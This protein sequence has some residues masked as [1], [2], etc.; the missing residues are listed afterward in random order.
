MDDAALR[1]YVMTLVYSIAAA[2]AGNDVTRIGK[3]LSLLEPIASLKIQLP[4]L[5]PGTT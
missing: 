1:I 4:G 2:V 5:R 3:L